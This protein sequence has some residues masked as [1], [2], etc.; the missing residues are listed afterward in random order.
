MEDREELE[1]YVVQVQKLELDR[2]ELIGSQSRKR[3]E[4]DVHESEIEALERLIREQS[5]GNGVDSSLGLTT[6]NCCPAASSIGV[7]VPNNNSP[8]AY[9]T[10]THTATSS[11]RTITSNSGIS[12]LSPTLSSFLPFSLSSP[13]I[14]ATATI[15]KRLLPSPLPPSA[16]QQLQSKLTSSSMVVCARCHQRALLLEKRTLLS[17]IHKEMEKIQRKINYTTSD[18]KHLK[19]TFIMP[20]ESCLAKDRD[21]WTR[22]LSDQMAS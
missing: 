14:V 9:S 1:Q 12:T 11:L 21:E 19:R 8:V 5:R 7:F 16:Q 15:T 6:E 4:R 3:Q 13:T 2:I 18:I 22:L 10:S 20:I 17:Q